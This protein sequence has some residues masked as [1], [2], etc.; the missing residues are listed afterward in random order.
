[1]SSS[2]IVF[3]PRP[4]PHT[5]EIELTN[6]CNAKCVFCPHSRMERPKGYMQLRQFADMLEQLDSH[7]SQFWLNRAAGRQIFPKITFAGLGEPLLHEDAPKFVYEAARRGFQTELVTNGARLDRATA[8]MLQDAGLNK[9]AI[10]L[11]SLNPKAYQ[12]IVGLPLSKVLGNVTA[13]LEILYGGSVKLSLWRV[14]SPFGEDRTK[15][16]ETEFSN[17]LQRFPEIVVLGPSEPWERDGQV[18]TTTHGFV[19]D[20]PEAGIRCSVQYFTMNVSWD[21][22]CVMCCVD[23]HR[24]IV[25][26]GNI[27]TDGIEATMNARQFLVENGKTPEICSSCRKWPDTQYQELF[28]NEIDRN[29]SPE[30]RAEARANRAQP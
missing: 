22:L 14:L 7:R 19:N 4:E 26:L 20:F 17:I 23:F 18:P 29:L 16:D 6:H 13:A 5:V 30:I 27:F 15:V 25:P 11:H 9:L 21:G 1:M 24:R 28:A 3:P 12:R 10:S 8:L 2:K